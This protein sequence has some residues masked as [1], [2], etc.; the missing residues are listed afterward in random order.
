[1][2][3]LLTY[4]H[5]LSRLLKGRGRRGYA[6][7]PLRGRGIRGSAAAPFKGRGLGRSLLRGQRTQVTNEYVLLLLCDGSLLR[8]QR[9]THFVCN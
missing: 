5:V 7:A 3:T 8:G 2:H 6:A 9:V 4:A 1:M